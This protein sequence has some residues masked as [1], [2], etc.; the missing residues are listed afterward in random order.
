MQLTRVIEERQA[1]DLACALS[2]LEYIRGLTFQ[3]FPW[4]EA[5]LESSHKR[6]VINGARQS[7]K[8]TL[9]SGLPCW[10]A[11]YQDRSLS[12]IVAATEKQ[13]VEDM[14]KI[15][16]FIAKDDRY[17]KIIRD[18]DSMLEFNNGS[19]ILVVPATEKAARGYSN[20]DIIILDEASRIE[21][22]VYRSGIRPMLTDNP[23]CVLLAISTPNG[24]DGFFYRAWQSDR[25]EKYEIRAPWEPGVIDWALVDAIK[26]KDYKKNRAAKGIRAWY[27]PRHRDREEQE[28]NLEEMGPREYL[29]EYCCE[30][31]EP[32][33]QVFKYNE[34]TG[35][36][37]SDVQPMELGN[38]EQTDDVPALELNR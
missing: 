5:I 22:P 28:E 32:E 29:Q 30:F 36:F 26:E 31:V 18:S 6:I 37:T 23:K 34:I 16:D 20:P 3:P 4:Q 17:P 12:I 14:E 38:V 8:S 21:D 24:R 35:L 19:R 11:K 2:P 25:W 15:K 33:G 10:V 7:G 27:S 1:R 9:V 13:A